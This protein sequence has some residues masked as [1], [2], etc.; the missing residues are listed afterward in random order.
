MDVAF[1]GRGETGLTVLEALLDAEYD[2]TSVWTCR[3]TP[4]V[5]ADP[6]DFEAV[7]AE[8]DLPFD[9]IEDVNDPENRER[10]AQCDP[11]VVVAIF[12]MDR[13]SREVL[14]VPEHGFLNLHGGKLPRYRGNAAAN[15][16]ILEGE[17]E[18][19]V[20]VHRMVPEL[21]AGP[22]LAQESVPITDDTTVKDLVA[23]TR[24]VGTRLVLRVLDGYRRD[25]PPPAI[26]QDEDD[27][28]R[29]YPRIPAYGR[30]DWTQ[31]A[32]QLDR[33]VRSLGDPYP[34][35]FT[36]HGTER[37]E[38]LAA[39]PRE[40]PGD[41]LAEPGH[42]VR[43]DEGDE[44]WVAT[45]D[46]ILAL[47]TIKPEDRDPMPASDYFGSIRERLGMDV[48][49]EV[50]ALERRIETLEAELSGEE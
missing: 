41:F 43:T 46:G 38:I 20:T 12:W 48:T 42:I 9:Y 18:L 50:R 11:D 44:V 31:S 15:W 5:G 27:A 23:A 7:A 6:D 8:H 2:L 22:V 26:E 24:E 40:H 33:H 17:S 14:D 30:L 34:D 29:C 19:G 36:Y 3:H 28:L 37:I 1:L 47:R 45:G 13:V 10:L 32:A 25:A 35:A 49:A 4:E 21:D 39:T 16:A